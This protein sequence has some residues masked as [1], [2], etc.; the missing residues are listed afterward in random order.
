MTNHIS[1]HAPRAGG[2]PQEKRAPLA[3][4][5]FQSTPPVRGATKGDTG[6]QGPT[7]ISIHAPRAGGD[8]I[9]ELFTGNPHQFQSTP[10]VR[11]ATVRR[12]SHI[13]I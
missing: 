1:I 3:P 11:G 7:G 8:V 10:P 9:E 2:D 6:A 12:Q 5:V 13:K 4:K